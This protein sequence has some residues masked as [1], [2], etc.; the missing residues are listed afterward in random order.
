MC[1]CVACRGLEVDGSGKLEW[2]MQAEMQKKE[3][4]NMI[5]LF[6][7]QNKLLKPMAVSLGIRVFLYS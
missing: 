6:E 2:K 3:N 5:T 7:V 1:L 4:R